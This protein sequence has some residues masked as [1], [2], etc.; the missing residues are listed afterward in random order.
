M[1][2][3]VHIQNFRQFRDLEL[4][5]LGRINLIT[6]QNNTGKTSLLEALN[7]VLAPNDPWVVA[8][9]AFLRG[10]GRLDVEGSHAWGFIFRDGD[11]E[12]SILLQATRFGGHCDKLT[13][14][15]LR[16]DQLTID[17][18]IATTGASSSST[19]STLSAPSRGLGYI[20][21]SVDGGTH[22]RAISRILRGG[23]GWT[24]ERHPATGLLPWY[25]LAQRP[26]DPG[27][28][29]GDNSPRLGEV[30]GEARR[31]SQLVVQR[32]KSE[33]IEAVRVVEPRLVDLE[34]IDLPPLTIAADIGLKSLVPLSYLGGGFGR[35]LK[36]IQAIL[37]TEGGV[38]LID[39]VEDGLHYSVLPAVWKAIIAAAHKHDVQIF[40]TTHS[41][42]AIEAAV[43]ATEGHE[44]S[45][46]FYRLDR[47]GADIEVVEGSDSRLRSAVKVG[48]EI[49]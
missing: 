10:L 42:E 17:D 1:L 22:G 6:G 11:V 4:K 34:V 45:L 25:F 28:V 39:E 32:R 9:H 14:N 12:N 16:D 18:G 44:G 2:R 31:F 37:T 8:T 43:E 26:P 46:A 20:Y 49:R 33:V 23:Q 5:N 27:H 3:S 48:Y 7:L 47:V 38:A 24:I 35:I 30:A 36:I 13:I 41:L 40:A 15:T 21:E 29:P 19:I